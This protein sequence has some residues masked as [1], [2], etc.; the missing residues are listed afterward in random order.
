M[1]QGQ[2]PGPDGS[3][4]TAPPSIRCRDILEHLYDYLDGEL[5]PAWERRVARHLELCGGCAA[6]LR[7]ERRFLEAIRRQGV[8]ASPTR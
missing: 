5:T 7:F 3:A 4:E 6:R 2:R 8:R 1:S